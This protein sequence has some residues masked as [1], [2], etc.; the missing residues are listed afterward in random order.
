MCSNLKKLIELHYDKVSK[1]PDLDFERIRK[2]KL[3]YEFDRK[4]HVPTWGYLSEGAYYQDASS[5]NSLLAAK[6]PIF[7]INAEDDPVSEHCISW[8]QANS[9]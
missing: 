8:T 4:V 9:F 2:V 5:I 1:N 6:I 7:A 3:P